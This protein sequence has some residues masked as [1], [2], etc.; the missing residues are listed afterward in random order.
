MYFEILH[1]IFFIWFYG[2]IFLNWNK[3]IQ[4]NVFKF[5]FENSQLKGS[6]NDTSKSKKVLCGILKNIWAVER[7]PVC[8]LLHLGY[9]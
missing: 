4:L 5:I 2:V 3:K 7:D 6:I 9:R 8:Q 1:R